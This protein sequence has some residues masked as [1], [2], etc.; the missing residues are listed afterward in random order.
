MAIDWKH[1]SNNFPQFI[2][3]YKRS[4]YIPLN[5][6]IKLWFRVFFFL[7]DVFQLFFCQPF[8]DGLLFFEAICLTIFGKS[9][10]TN[11]VVAGI[12]K[13]LLAND[14][15]SIMKC[16]RINFTFFG[17]IYPISISFFI[18][19]IIN[20]VIWRSISGKMFPIQF[21]NHSAKLR[22]ARSFTLNH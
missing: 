22:Y 12:D 8:C 16:Y 6:I 7:V 15:L 18:C 17:R 2:C 21:C 11:C 20:Q 13:C 3:D 14:L 1:R 4:T 10:C 19:I 5:C 9:F